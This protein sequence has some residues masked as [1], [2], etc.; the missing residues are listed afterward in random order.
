MLEFPISVKQ[1]AVINENARITDQAIGIRL[2]DYSKSAINQ[3][4]NNDVITCPHDLIVRFFN[5]F[6]FVFSNLVTDASFM[7][8]S[9]LFPEL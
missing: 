2:L 7:S 1:K 4:K 8:I 5:V 9:L 3:K 6:M